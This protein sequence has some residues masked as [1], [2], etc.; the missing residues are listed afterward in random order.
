MTPNTDA[1]FD[2]IILGQGLAGSLLARELAQRDRRVLVVDDAAPN[3]A[4][5]VAAGLVNPV[6]GP[7]LVLTP[8]ADPLLGTLHQTIREIETSLGTPL[9]HPLPL[10]RRFESEQMRD[11]WQR[12]LRDSAYS[13]YLDPRPRSPADVLPADAPLGGFRQHR[14]GWLDSR[15]LLGLLGD[16]LHARG[17]LRRDNLRHDAIRTDRHGVRI[18]ALRAATLIFC[19]GYRLAQNPWFH[20]LPLQP[21]KGEILTLRTHEPLPRH[22]ASAGRWL[23]PLDQHRFRFGATN[24]WRDIDAEPTQDGKL[25]LLKDLAERFP[26][27]ADAQLIDHRA[28]VRPG[29]PDRYPFLGRHPDHPALA[30][31]NGFGSKGSLMIPWYAQRFADFL[32]AAAPLPAQADIARFSAAVPRSSEDEPQRSERRREDTE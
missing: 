19:E 2:F 29:T 8:D 25:G 15:R 27:L 14:T 6:T 32:T 7:R 4:S 22:I 28:G 30:V 16:W 9:F 13:G 11:R 5:R 26:S 23:V 17:L 1:T 21:A 3:A 12:R 10:I 24:G 18:G 31:F 20:W